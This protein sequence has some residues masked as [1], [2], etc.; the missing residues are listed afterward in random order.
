MTRKDYIDALNK[1]DFIAENA[2]VLDIFTTMREK[3]EDYDCG[4]PENSLED[5]FDEYEYK[6]EEDCVDAVVAVLRQHGLKEGKKCMSCLH[7]FN[8]LYKRNIVGWYED[9]T[10]EDL[11]ELRD[12][13]VLRIK[14]GGD[15][16]EEE[17]E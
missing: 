11:E 8:G 10:L 7:E 16:N 13:F 6:D 1:I 9:V 2:D 3:I 15:E 4:F 5:L 17:E 12:E 14:E